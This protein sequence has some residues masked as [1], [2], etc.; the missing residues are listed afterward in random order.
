MFVCDEVAGQLGRDESGWQRGRSEIPSEEAW[1]NGKFHSEHTF[2]PPLS[3]DAWAS[4][5]R[6][7]GAQALPFKT[8]LAGSGFDD[9]AGLDGM[10]G[11]ARIVALG[12]ASHGTA[13]FFQMKHRLLEYLVETKG[14]TVFAMEAPWAEAQLAD[15]FIKTG[16]GS[17]AAALVAMH[18]RIWQ[19]EE[20][21][22]MLDWMRAYNSTRGER[23][24]LSFAGFDM[25]SANVAIRQ[26]IGSVRPN[27]R[28]RS[29]RRSAAL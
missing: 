24:E 16:E 5:V 28:R 22:A 8:V 15:R 12:E 1:V 11:N 6:E 19:T 7:L 10:I 9:L 4:I 13:E 25:Q 17:A 29:G 20:V 18:F 3:A 21:R 14:F 26:V 23:P 27:G 2:E